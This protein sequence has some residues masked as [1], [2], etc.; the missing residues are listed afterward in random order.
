MKLLKGLTEKLLQYLNRGLCVLIRK[1][2]AQKAV[3]SFSPKRKA[4]SIKF[5]DEQTKAL[6]HIISPFLEPNMQVFEKIKDMLNQ[7]FGPENNQI[8]KPSVEQIA[9]F[10]ELIGFKQPGINT[11]SSSDLVSRTQDLG[12]GLYSIF[13]FFPEVTIRN[14]YG[15]EHKITDL[16]LILKMDNLGRTHQTIWGIR[17]SYSDRELECGYA[18]SHLPTRQEA[19]LGYIGRFCLGEGPIRLILSKLSKEFNEVDFRMLLMHIKKYV[20]WESLEGTPHIEMSRM[21]CPSNITAPYF[22]NLNRSIL[23]QGVAKLRSHLKD[24]SLFHTVINL[25]RTK[26]G[27]IVHPTEEMEKLVGLVMR[28]KMSPSDFGKDSMIDLLCYKDQQGQYISCR[29][30]F[31]NGNSNLMK[32]P[33]RALFTFKGKEVFIKQNQSQSINKNTVYGPPQIVQELC[34]Q[35]SREFTIESM[36]LEVNWGSSYTGPDIIKA[37]PA[38]PVAMRQDS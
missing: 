1:E 38:N 19:T 21:G 20:A 36:D 11:M 6:D 3:F 4:M 7:S 18:H 25:E 15:M 2:I 17:A 12:L 14:S 26:E 29:S 33:T 13:I 22:L 31:A 30:S 16:Y 28:N 35:L 10:L 34:R 8:T 5:S 24:H 37:P 27:M 32:P 9:N 23:L